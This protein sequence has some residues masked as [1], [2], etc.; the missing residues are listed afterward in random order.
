MSVKNLSSGIVR[1]PE[2][3]VTLKVAPSATSTGARSDGWTMYEGPPPK[4]ALYLFSPFA[5]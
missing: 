1:L 3:P 4:M 5:A 2:A